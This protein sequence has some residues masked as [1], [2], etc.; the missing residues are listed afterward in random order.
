MTEQDL[1]GMIEAGIDCKHLEVHGPDG[2]HFAA[3]IVSDEFEGKTPIQR[4][5]IVYRCLGAK[6]GTDIHA[7]NMKTL[8][9]EEWRQQ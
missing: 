7:L 3:L 5:Q 1:H 9:T 4:H 8:T 6:M 2:V